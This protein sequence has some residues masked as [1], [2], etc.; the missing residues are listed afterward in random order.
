MPQLTYS[1]PADTVTTARRV[2][3]AMARSHGW[4]RV[5][6]LFTRQVGPRQYECDVHVS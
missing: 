4:R 1:V 2:A 5:V 3:E 6:V